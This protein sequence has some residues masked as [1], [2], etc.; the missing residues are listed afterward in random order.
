MIARR[1]CTSGAM[2]SNQNKEIRMNELANQKIKFLILYHLINEDFF[3][4]FEQ[5]LE[6]KGSINCMILLN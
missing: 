2:S 1:T 3:M 4:I 5:Q 6:L